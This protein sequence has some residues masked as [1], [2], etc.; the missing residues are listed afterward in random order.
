VDSSEKT[1]PRAGTVDLVIR[2]EEN[3]PSVIAGIKVEGNAKTSEEFVR[4]RVP[5]EEGSKV[6]GEKVSLL[7]RRLT[8]S[9]A[10]KLGD[11]TFRPSATAAKPDGSRPVDLVIR[12]R[13][14][15]PFRLEYGLNYDSETGIG[16]LADFS[17]RNLLGEGRLLGYRISADTEQ[18]DQRIYF[19]QPF[20]GRRDITTTVD[21][22]RERQ[23]REAVDYTQNSLTVQQLV[24]FRRKFTLS[25]GYR[26]RQVEGT[27]G[28]TVPFTGSITPLI[29]TLSRDR[30]NDVFD[31]TGGSY[32]SQSLEY[33]PSMLGGSYSYYRYFGQFFKYLGLTRPAPVPGQQEEH[34]R[35]VFATGIRV[36]LLERT[37]GERLIPFPSERFFGGGSTTVRGFSQNSLGPQS[38]QGEALGGQAVF[39]LNNELRFPL[40]KFLDAAVFVDI[41]NVWAFPSEFSLRDVRKTAGFGIRLRNPLI[42]L[43]FDYGW[44]LDRRPGEPAGAFHF[45]LGQAY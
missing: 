34:P 38:A 23:I 6:E 28:D 44:K 43:R 2:I 22:E 24:E 14:P 26:Y 41:G 10:Y 17:V 27:V 4:R 30:R 11:L 19:S 29:T 31:A 7:R 21:L 15:K 9:G 5:L 40:Y 39:F 13:E 25:Y 8:N 45:G 37:G 32:I 1:D 42:L 12:V 20:L 3:T 35:F 18:Q 16:G 33:S 36:G